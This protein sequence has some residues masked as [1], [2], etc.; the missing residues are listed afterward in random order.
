M[1]QATAAVDSALPNSTVVILPG[2]QH[3]A[4]DRDP[5][6]LVGEVLRFLQG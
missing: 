1:Q 3:I 4:M 5:E 6:L 2:Q